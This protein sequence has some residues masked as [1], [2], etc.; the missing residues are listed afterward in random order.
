MMAASLL[1]AAAV[2]VALVRTGTI[3]EGQD[4]QSARADQVPAQTTPATDVPAGVP[5][6]ESAPQDAPAEA[7]DERTETAQ[8]PDDVEAATPAL[9]PATVYW[10]SVS[11]ERLE[12]VEVDVSVVAP[13]SSAVDALVSGRGA[14]RGTMPIWQAQGIQ[15]V[16]RD[17]GL[18]T[19]DFDETFDS[20]Y[21]RGSA[22]EVA[23]LAPIIYTVT[24]FDGVDSVLFT[25][26]GRAPQ[27]AGAFDLNTPLGREDVPGLTE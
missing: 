27:A 26:G 12:P 14:P 9:V 7:A 16:N 20:Y 1:C 15:S 17:G 8:A 3:G 25:V 18:V 5:S 24:G 19:L 4:L 11:G 6:S 23:M 10:P 21:P 13:I 22:E 2:A